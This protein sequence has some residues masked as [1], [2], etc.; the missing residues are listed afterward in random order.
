MA[1]FKLKKSGGPRDLDLS[2]AGLKL[3][4]RVLSWA[5]TGSSSP[6]WRAPSASVGK[7][8]RSPTTRRGGSSHRP[9]RRVRG[10]AGRRADRAVR[11]A[12]V[13]HRG[14]RRRGP[15]RRDRQA[16]YQRARR[17]PA[18][19]AS[20]ASPRRTLP[21]HRTRGP[22]RSRGGVLAA[23]DRPGLSRRRRGGGGACR[24]GLPRRPACSRSTAARTSSRG[25]GSV[26]SRAHPVSESGRL[27]P[28]AA[29][30]GPV[31]GSGAAG[32]SGGPDRP[33]FCKSLAADGT[34]VM[35]VGTRPDVSR[36]VSDVF[37]AAE[38]AQAV[39]VPEAA[40]R[41]LIAGGEVATIDGRLVAGPE[42]LR[43]AGACA[44]VPVAPLPAVTCSGAPFSSGRAEGSPGRVRRVLG[45]RSRPRHRRRPG[46]VRRATPAGPIRGAPAPSP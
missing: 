5:T 8:A 24:R 38:I 41:A 15:C 21:G 28:S 11:G 17:L 29:C 32:R 9:R 20:R 18:A 2:M 43:A 35:P 16:P 42:A 46:L 4:S 31:S 14:V 19:G 1:L 40:V 12:A 22:R 23:L 30:G 34:G 3:G 25:P 27:T 26:L 7:P 39:R 33:A 37:T 44:T 36:A 10:R 45:R 13:R 6:C